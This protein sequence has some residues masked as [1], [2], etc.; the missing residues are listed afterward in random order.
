MDYRRYLMQMVQRGKVIKMGGK[1]H[2]MNTEPYYK[3][4][5]SGSTGVYSGSGSIKK[6]NY[7]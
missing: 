3:K 1:L 6:I 2:I 4:S 5:F 7:R